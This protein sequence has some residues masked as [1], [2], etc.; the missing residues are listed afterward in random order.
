MLL[1]VFLDAMQSFSE[2]SVK[3]PTSP[4]TDEEPPIVSL[5]D[6]CQY[7]CDSVCE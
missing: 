4:L 5:E 6:F 2:V 7:S 1:S 3:C